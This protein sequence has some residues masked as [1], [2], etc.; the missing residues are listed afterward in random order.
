MNLAD[1]TLPA[2]A[3]AQ[4]EQGLTALGLSLAPAQ[5]LQLLAYAALLAKWNRTYNLTALRLP[6]QMVSHHLLDS[7]AILPAVLDLTNTQR[8]A[9][10]AIALLDVG[11]GGG[12]PGIPLAIAC[13][14]LA[15]T[16][17]DS[18]SKKTAF[19]TQAVIELGL[20]NVRVHTGRIEAGAASGSLGTFPL[21]V[22]RAFAEVAAFIAC[23]RDVLAPAGCWLAMKGVLSADEVA[24]LP[25]TIHLEQT[26]AL[27]VPGLDA[28]RHLL[29][30]RERC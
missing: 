27:Q 9:G 7:L 13:P 21:V 25:P 15:V 10:E 23:S 1:T 12:L 4:L 20:P 11:T 30:L 8:A 16:L 26:L 18:N 17:L 3:R 6:E 14:Q 2:S 5:I 22:S 24:Q 28:V 29:I 19:L